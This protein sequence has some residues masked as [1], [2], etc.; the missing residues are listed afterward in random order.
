MSE[1]PMQQDL[2]QLEMAFAA[3]PK[4]FVPLTQ[5]YLQL[6]RFME[7]MVVCKKGIKASPESIDGKL[8]LARVYAE[9][10]KVPKAV[11]EL[12]AIFAQSP[13]LKG[14]DAAACHLLLGQMNERAGRFEEAIESFKEALRNDRGNS[15]AKAALKAKGVDF[16]PGPSPEELA[17]AAAAAKKAVDDAEI[18]AAQQ[19]AEAAEAARRVQEAKARAMGQAISPGRQTPAT[20]SGLP[21]SLP[22]QPV[23]PAFAAA[24]AQNLYGYSGPQQPPT[25]RGL[26]F[27]F[28]L[29]RVLDSPSPYPDDD[30]LP[31][32]PVPAFDPLVLD[33]D[34]RHRPPFDTP[35]RQHPSSLDAPLS[36]GDSSDSPASDPADTDADASYDTPEAQH[37]FAD[38]TTMPAPD[39]SE[40][41]DYWYWNE[42]SNCHYY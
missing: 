27:G 26:G 35:R 34:Y 37:D 5:A 11:E 13:E 12:K 17:A 22:P 1:P 18:A 31:P 7:A 10:G 41:P 21:S 24:Y 23:D 16:D 9:Q 8:L 42:K 36:G 29:R 33:T 40:P 28:T 32:E 4:A 14:P 2:S 25:K 6:G 19:A 38:D 20:G 30:F 15:E 39:Q 3:D